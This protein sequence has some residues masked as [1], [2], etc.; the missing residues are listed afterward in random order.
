MVSGDEHA[1]R[2]FY[3]AYF[4]R[5]TRYLL[6][7]TAGNE[8]IVRE[9]LQN[10]LPRVVRY[11]KVF[12]DDAS[13]WSWL[14][15]L[16]RSAR[17]DEHRKRRRYLAFLDR[18]TTHATVTQPAVFAESDEHRKLE[19]LLDRALAE[20][21]RAEREVIENKYFR[22]QS[23]QEIAEQM[24]TTQKAVESRLGRIRRKLRQAILTAQPHESAE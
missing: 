6:V 23:V 2:R 22:H 24:N 16:A 20:L 4:D 17:T 11:I 12:P 9:T 3:D 15:V 21:P 13:F 10:T 14:T 1:Y 5:L 18:F 8:E 7:V 19:R